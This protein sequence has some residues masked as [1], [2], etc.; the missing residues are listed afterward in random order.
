M[1]VQN[2]DEAFYTVYH[3]ILLKKLKYY[4]VREIRNKQFASCL[5]NS[6]YFYLNAYK[7]N[8]ADANCG[9]LQPFIRGRVLLIIYLNYLHLAVKY[10]EVHHFADHTFALNFNC[11]VKFINL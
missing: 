5:S 6:K 8:P 3:H 11:F 4:G 7:S 9:L 10:S 1:N 2:A